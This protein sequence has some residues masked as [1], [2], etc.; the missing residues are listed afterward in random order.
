MN[1]LF[2]HTGYFLFEINAVTNKK[3]FSKTCIIKFYTNEV[4]NS[5]K[6]IGV[7]NCEHANSPLQIDSANLEDKVH[8]PPKSIPADLE[9]LS[10]TNLEDSTEV[11]VSS[12]DDQNNS[13]DDLLDTTIEESIETSAL[14]E[15]VSLETKV[16]IPTINKNLL[17]I[18]KQILTIF[19]IKVNHFSGFK[20]ALPSFI[21]P[22]PQPLSLFQLPQQ[23]LVNFKNIELKMQSSNV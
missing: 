16:N 19:L 18:L 7:N 15:K 22:A 14:S 5:Q 11:I 6:L 3:T 2:T 1:N 17:N 13:L 8:I 10:E 4:D 12:E 23:P 21:E 20:C 9:K